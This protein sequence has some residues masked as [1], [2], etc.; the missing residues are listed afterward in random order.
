MASFLSQLNFNSPTET[1]FQRTSWVS[2]PDDNDFYLEK[3]VNAFLIIDFLIVNCQATLHSCF[4]VSY[5]S[6]SESQI[7][8]LNLYWLMDQVV[9]SWAFDELQDDV[10]FRVLLLASGSKDAL[11]SLVDHSDSYDLRQPQLGLEKIQLNEGNISLLVD[12]NTEELRHLDFY[13]HAL[14]DNYKYF[15]LVDSCWSTFTCQSVSS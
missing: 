10:L 3:S 5:D 2:Y 9:F 7:A 1:T 6:C 15:K 11:K 4:I 12:E 13:L 14:N 8:P